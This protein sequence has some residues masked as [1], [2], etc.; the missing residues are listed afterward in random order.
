MDGIAIL[1]ELRDVIPLATEAES[2]DNAVKNPARVCA[3]A[4]SGLWRIVFVDQPLDQFPKVIWEFP[5][6]R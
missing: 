6:C 3:R 5:D 1:V 4:P 2:E